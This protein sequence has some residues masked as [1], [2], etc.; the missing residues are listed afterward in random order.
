MLSTDE[1]RTSE[2]EIGS[3]TV[4]ARI[5]SSWSRFSS[6]VTK[7]NKFAVLTDDIIRQWY[8]FSLGFLLSRRIVIARFWRLDNYDTVTVDGYRTVVKGEPDVNVVV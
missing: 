8:L 4:G 1:L 2:L 7:E 5:D 3:A 6:S